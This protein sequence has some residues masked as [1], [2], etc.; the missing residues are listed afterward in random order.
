MVINQVAKLNCYPLLKIEELL[1]ALSGGKVVLKVDLS[2]AYQQ[3]PLAE[4]SKGLTVINTHCGL[5]HFNR[6]PFGIS[7][8]LGIFQ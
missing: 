4:E 3:V 8:A 7:S 2:Q 6:M 1:A 5:F